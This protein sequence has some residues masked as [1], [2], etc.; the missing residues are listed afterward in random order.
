MP[1]T[2]WVDSA[3]KHQIHGQIEYENNQCMICGWKT[4]EIV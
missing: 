3:N 2:A 4:G 1:T